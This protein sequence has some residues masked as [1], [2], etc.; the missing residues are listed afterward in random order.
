L[1]TG[2]SLKKTVFLLIG[3]ILAAG[4]LTVSLSG[5]SHAQGK[6]SYCLYRKN[7][8]GYG[9]AI[10]FAARQWSRSP[11]VDV[12][13]HAD[14]TC[15]AGATRIFIRGFYKADSYVGWG[16]EGQ[17]IQVN[18]YYLWFSP[19]WK[20]GVITHELGHVVG[21]RNHYPGTVMAEDMNSFTVVPQ[22]ILRMAR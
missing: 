13:V 22:W 2:T 7:T 20:R 5:V 12:K 11:Y 10:H 17:S 21:V 15:S 18:R 1:S 19:T 6:H 16:T 14:G 9:D 4:F 8:R 3:A